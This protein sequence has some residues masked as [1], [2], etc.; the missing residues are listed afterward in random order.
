MKQF[1]NEDNPFKAEINETLALNG[2]KSK[3]NLAIIL[4][5]PN[6]KTL[7]ALTNSGWNTEK[8][9]IPNF[10]EDYFNI[11]QVHP[12]TFHISLNKLLRLI[13]PHKIGLIYMDYMCTLQ[14]NSTC[15]PIKDLTYLF[16]NELLDY[17]SI[18]GITL[19]AR[20]KLNQ[21]GFKHTTLADMVELIF[22]LAY[23]NHYKLKKLPTGGCYHNG[24]TMYSLIF[25]IMK[26]DRLESKIYPTKY[27]VEDD[28]DII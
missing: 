19:S 10:S 16:N 26:N 11:N 28:D 3:T 2:K 20:S 22:N 24:G 5:G 13:K 4:D 21:S 12:K 17:G 8:I 6:C 15:R 14:G 23:S 18:L 25:K 9:Y 1:N 7:N 27:K